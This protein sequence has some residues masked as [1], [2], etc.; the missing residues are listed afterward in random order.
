MALVEIRAGSFRTQIQFVKRRVVTIEV[1]RVIDGLA[2]RI[3]GEH[4]EAI[5]L[6]RFLNSRMPP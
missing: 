2:V 5:D 4:R 6:K 3:V 1:C